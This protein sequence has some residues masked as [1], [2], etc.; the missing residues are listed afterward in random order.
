MPKRTLFKF[1]Q[2]DGLD[3]GLKDIKVASLTIQNED[4]FH[5]KNLYKLIHDW[6]DEEGFK[7]IYGERGGDGNPEIFYLE[8]ISGSGGRE[9]RIRWRALRTP[10]DST[11]YRYFL[12]IDFLTINM[13]A[14]E[15]MH[16]GYKMKTDRGD[17]TITIEA[18]LQLDYNN[19]W[20][21]TSFLKSKFIQ[22]LFRNRVYKEQIESHK[23]DL[24]KTTYRLQNTIKQYLKLKTLYDMP[25][26][27]HPEKGL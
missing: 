16:Q 18:W 4:T 9:H 7:D 24:Y 19:E 13:K 23:V 20:K 5:L 22:N 2:R 21:D 25:K 14:M 27:F 1:E 3:K 15:V 8:R 10:L 6:L 12:K 26:P 11:Y 17:I